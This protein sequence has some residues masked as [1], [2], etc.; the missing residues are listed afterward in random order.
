VRHGLRLG[1]LDSEP[2]PSGQPVGHGTVQIRHVPELA[3]L[4]LDTI[5]R[6]RCDV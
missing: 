1:G 4:N 2:K 6:P 3:R 5:E